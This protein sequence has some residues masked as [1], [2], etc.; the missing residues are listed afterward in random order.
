MTR[1]SAFQIACNEVTRLTQ[2]V[3]DLTVEVTVVKL[4]LKNTEELLENLSRR[5]LEGKDKSIISATVIEADRLEYLSKI[6]LT[7]EQ[8]NYIGT[9]LDDCD[10]QKQD[11]TYLIKDSVDAYNGGAR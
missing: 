3:K 1:D 6:E 5:R 2:I 11:Y 8:I 7:E 10:E 4:K 9:W